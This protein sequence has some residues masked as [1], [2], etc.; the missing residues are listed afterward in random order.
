MNYF[1]QIIYQNKKIISQNKTIQ[2]LNQF[3]FLLIAK[4]NFKYQEK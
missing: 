3:N 4:N 2:I 1:F